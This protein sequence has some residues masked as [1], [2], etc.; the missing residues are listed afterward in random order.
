MLWPVASATVSTVGRT[1]FTVV[2]VIVVVIVDDIT[3]FSRQMHS[4][5]NRV[6]IGGTARFEF[7]F[8]F[9]SHLCQLWLIRD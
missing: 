1:T 3:T 9:S 5:S 7:E 4:C 6:G 2:V 8:R